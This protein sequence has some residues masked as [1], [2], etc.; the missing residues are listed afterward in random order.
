[1]SAAA[2]LDSPKNNCSWYGPHLVEEMLSEWEMTRVI[3]DA[4]RVV[5]EKESEPGNYL[6]FKPLHRHQE[7][8][9]NKQRNRIARLRDYSRSARYLVTLTVDPQRYASDRDAYA[10]LLDSWRKIYHRLKRR[11]DCLQVLRAA[12]PQ[13]NGQPHLHA[14]LWGVHLP[15]GWAAE[16]YREVGSGYVH[17]SPVRHGNPGAVSYLGKYLTKAS[18]LTLGA[19]TRW[20]AQTLTVCGQEM[21]EHLGPLIDEKPTGEWVLVE[22]VRCWDDAVMYFGEQYAQELYAD[23]TGPP[24]T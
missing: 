14:L 2:V 7:R 6:S 1:M 3:R 21:R 19:L 24:E 4:Q 17:V 8:Y 9:R 16:M 5:V 15:R 18:D 10:G 13:K 11:S 22:F 12:E 20:G 23:P